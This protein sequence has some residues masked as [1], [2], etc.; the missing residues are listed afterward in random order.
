MREML[1]IQNIDGLSDDAKVLLQLLGGA[2]GAVSNTQLAFL[3]DAILRGVEK[4]IEKAQSEGV[5]IKQEWGTVSQIASILGMKRAG[6]NVLLSRLKCQGKVSTIRG[7]NSIGE[8]K[9][10]T[11]YNIAEVIEALKEEP[12]KK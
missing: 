2:S 1:L 7:L 4:A 9:G 8:K 5:A 3:Y 6:A 12:I 10:D 11:R